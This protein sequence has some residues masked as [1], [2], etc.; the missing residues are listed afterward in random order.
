MCAETDQGCAELLGYVRDNFGLEN[1]EHIFSCSGS[2]WQKGKILDQSVE[3]FDS[4]VHDLLTVH[5]VIARNFLPVIEKNAESS[6]TI[7]TGESN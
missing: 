3:E 6:Y 7:I 4:V 5:F 2:W 1:I